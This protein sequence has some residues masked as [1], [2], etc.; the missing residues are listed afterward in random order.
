MNDLIKQHGK[1]I[2]EKDYWF[3]C[4]DKNNSSNIL[5]R[6]T[7]QI[8]NWV[9]NINP[10]NVLQVNWKKEKLLPPA[11]RTY[12][13]TLEIIIGGVKKSIQG[14]WKNIPSEWK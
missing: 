3:L 13:E 5:I 12:E 8:N 6:G 14:F 7:K 1:N 10:S 9:P 4:V 2:P 11:E